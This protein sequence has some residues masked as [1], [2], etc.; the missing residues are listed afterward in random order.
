MTSSKK[1]WSIIDLIDW[2]TNHF[3]E[4]GIENAR[5]EMEWFLC[6]VLNYQRIDLYL[7][8]DFVYE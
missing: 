7:K 4:R 2:G 1:T 3:T 5:R 6:D 8:L